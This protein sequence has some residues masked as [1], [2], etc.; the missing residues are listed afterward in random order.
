MF[1][2]FNTL[3][4]KDYTNGFRMIW[5][6]VYLIFTFLLYIKKQYMQLIINA[7]GCLFIINSTKM[8]SA[9]VFENSPAS[10]VIW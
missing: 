9:Y 8:E 1:S 4:P 10:I 2:P 5:L 3:A 6:W 7:Y